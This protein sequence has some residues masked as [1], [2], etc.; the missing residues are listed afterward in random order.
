MFCCDCEIRDNG[1]KKR[2]K[3]TMHITLDM[4]PTKVG[5]RDR[6]HSSEMTDLH[7]LISLLLPLSLSLS[8]F[9]SHQRL[10]V[11]TP[12]HW[13]H[14]SDV[15]VL[16]AF[17]VLLRLKLGF[18]CSGVD[19]PTRDTPQCSNAWISLLFYCILIGLRHCWFTALLLLLKR[20][21]VSAKLPSHSKKGPSEHLTWDVPL[22][23]ATDSK[24]LME[25]WKRMCAHSVLCHCTEVESSF[26]TSAISHYFLFISRHVLL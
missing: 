22:P 7:N 2:G 18:K 4:W 14:P 23:R 9:L 21:P 3:T 12:K 8:L 11:K 24:C 20:I 15:I 13:P 1:E 26:I 6:N 25:K 19:S 16:M 5:Q 17:D 10:A